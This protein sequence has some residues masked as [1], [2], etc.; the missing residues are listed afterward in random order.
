MEFWKRVWK[1]PVLWTKIW[2]SQSTED[3]TNLRQQ[4][5]M[6]SRKVMTWW[7]VMLNFFLMSESKQTACEL[8]Q[9]CYVQRSIL[10]CQSSRSNWDN[11]EL[12][13]GLGL[14]NNVQ[15]TTFVTGQRSCSAL[16]AQSWRCSYLCCIHV[17]EQGWKTIVARFCWFPA[18]PQ[19][20]ELQEKAVTR[21]DWKA[22]DHPRICWRHAFCGNF[23]STN[24]ARAW[25]S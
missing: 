9:S 25:T 1:K 24:W 15:Y 13:L 16:I 21:N 4:W 17:Y 5:K 19:R 8:F 2:S 12:D 11:R 23:C 10:A 18:D 3:L 14:V 6:G 22:K 7:P 20:G